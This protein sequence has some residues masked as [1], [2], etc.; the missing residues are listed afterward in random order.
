[1]TFV[2]VFPAWAMLA[3]AAV[4]V[5]VRMFTL[6]RVLVR[7]G[8]GRYRGV[9]LRW[10]GLTMAVLLL[11][12]A[13]ARP[14]LTPERGQAP[15]PPQ[16][17]TA[18]NTNIF[19]V[20][21]RSVNQRV[22]DFA[23]EQTRMAGVRADILALMNQYPRARFSVIGFS[24]QARLD[25]PLSD[26]AWSLKPF[27]EGLSPYTDVP[28]DAMFTVNAGA[29]G[30]LLATKLAQA[31][32][33]FPQSQSLVF[34]FGSGAPGSRVQQGSFDVDN[35]LIAGGAVLGYGTAKGG[36]VPQGF[37][38]GKLVYM[39]DQ[40]S[41]AP[42]NS[43]LSDRTL[44]EVA[45]QLGVPYYSRTDN[46][47]ITPVLPALEPTAAPDDNPVV[48]SQ[49]IDRTELYWLFTMLAAALILVEVYLTIRDIRRT[50]T[51]T[52]DVEL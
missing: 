49:T 46:Q 9:V 26:D 4:L 8:R 27:I 11:L 13:A 39:A 3:I 47:P 14:G 45:T 19:F 28:L 18:A 7:T 37:Y 12:L 25:W 52:K 22:E 1:M 10:A 50:H 30:E 15:P 42:L 20:V 16:A 6:Y 51:H 23:P 48:A 29:A 40:Q 44:N 32:A 21:D 33:D 17:Q 31:E 36:P 41:G 5:A 35:N 43:A 24:A 2:P 38:G 34:Y